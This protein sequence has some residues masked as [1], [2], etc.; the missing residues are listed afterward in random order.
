MVR[1]LEIA[2][3]PHELDLNIPDTSLSKFLT[4]SHLVTPPVALQIPAQGVVLAADGHW[5]PPVRIHE[6]EDVQLDVF[7]GLVFA[8][9]RVVS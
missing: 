3:Q 1:A 5:W 9:G 7:S 6:L 2:G 8:K 4:R